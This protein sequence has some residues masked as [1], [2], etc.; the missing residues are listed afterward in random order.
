MCLDY[1]TDIETVTTDRAHSHDM[2][3]DTL[4]YPLSA[5]PLFGGFRPSETQI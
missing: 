1:I 2:I 5:S 4:T 3:T